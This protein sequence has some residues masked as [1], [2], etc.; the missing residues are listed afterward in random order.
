ML[1]SILG[2]VA[3][4]RCSKMIRDLNR[5]RENRMHN[6][7]DLSKFTIEKK[8]CLKDCK[9]LK[10]K[11]KIYVTFGLNA[12]DMTAS[13]YHS[14]WELHHFSNIFFSHSGKNAL[15]AR[16]L[17]YRKK[18][19]RE[20]QTICTFCINDGIIGII[21]FPEIELSTWPSAVPMPTLHW[22]IEMCLSLCEN[23]SN[24]S[25]PKKEEKKVKQISFTL[26]SYFNL[27][28]T[29]LERNQ[30]GYFLFLFTMKT[31]RTSNEYV[32]IW[33]ILINR[34]TKNPNEMKAN[35]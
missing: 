6:R 25:V 2:M 4:H 7:K 32:K 5:W 22:K 9:R 11:T 17:S 13:R 8:K 15:L 18:I 24:N 10:Q 28:E 21:Q 12:E 27:R 26:I 33:K 1:L 16:R 14:L 30:I 23:W 19:D 31:N 20:A 35:D 34:K 3:N 29:L